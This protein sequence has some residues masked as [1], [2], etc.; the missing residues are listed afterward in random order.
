MS[1]WSDPILMADVQHFPMGFPMGFPMV[2]PMGFHSILN[3]ADL[4]MVFSKVKGG[5]PV[6]F[7]IVPQET[8][9]R[10]VNELAVKTGL[11]PTGT[12]NC[13]LLDVEAMTAVAK[14]KFQCVMLLNISYIV[15]V[16]G[17]VKKVWPV[18]VHTPHTQAEQR[19][20]LDV[21][22]QPIRADLHRFLAASQRLFPCPADKVKPSNIENMNVP[23]LPSDCWTWRKIR[24]TRTKPLCIPFFPLVEIRVDRITSKMLRLRTACWWPH[25]S[26]M[27]TS[28]LKATVEVH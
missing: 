21:A 20:L 6:G 15:V 4:P 11:L 22:G 19:G 16:Y 18:L 7:I 2:F 5:F 28:T 1:S 17:M 12:V 3:S 27:P 24:K 23:R 14:S 26:T 10:K 13:K 9:P 8:T 25:T